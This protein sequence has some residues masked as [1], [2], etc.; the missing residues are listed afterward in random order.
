MKKSTVV[1][2][3]MTSMTIEGHLEPECDMF[4]IPV[5]HVAQARWDLADKPP[6]LQFSSLESGA[7]FCAIYPGVGDI[8]I[9]VAPGEC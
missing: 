8:E 5:G 4:E 3:N 7:L 2:E 6:V 9:S 1:L